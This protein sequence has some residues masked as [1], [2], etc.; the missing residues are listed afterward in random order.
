MG[1]KRI[2][3][4]LLCAIPALLACSKKEPTTP[5]DAYTND[6]RK[7]ETEDKNLATDQAKERADLKGDQAKDAADTQA[8]IDKQAADEKA[9]RAKFEAD[10]KTRLEKADVRIQAVQ[11]KIAKAKATAK[12]K[13][14]DIMT[15]VKEQREALGKSLGELPNVSKDRWAT[16]KAELDSNANTLEAN[17]DEVEKA[18]GT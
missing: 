18:V 2:G 15:R 3:A 14:N 10:L 9:D 7:F 4:V 1:T 17:L 5:Q 11:P 6:A 8:D 16:T 13:A 12:T